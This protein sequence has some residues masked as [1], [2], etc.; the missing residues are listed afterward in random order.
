MFENQ[1]D[2]AQK[3]QKVVDELGRHAMTKM[4]ARHIHK[5]KALDLGLNVISLEDDNRLQELVLSV[6]HSCMLTFEQTAALKLIENHRG[7][8]Y[9][10]GAPPMF[11][12]ASQLNNPTPIS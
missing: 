4:H 2:S 10:L 11:A 6:H 3:A 12:I 1:P 8:C 5:A 7:T 9:A